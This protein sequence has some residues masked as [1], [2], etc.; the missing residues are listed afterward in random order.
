MT[1]ANTPSEIYALSEHLKLH[2]GTSYVHY[3]AYQIVIQK[4]MKIPLWFDIPLRIISFFKKSQ[5]YK[6]IVYLL[7]LKNPNLA[8]AL[9]TDTTDHMKYGKDTEDKDSVGGFSQREINII[10]NILKNIPRCYSAIQYN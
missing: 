2:I 9:I 1:K 4:L 6:Q 7:F 10:E 3:I 8:D 5:D